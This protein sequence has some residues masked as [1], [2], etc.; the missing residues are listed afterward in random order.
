MDKKVLEM[1]ANK[2]LATFR[3]ISWV[4]NYSKTEIAEKLEIARST[5]YKR[6]ENNSWTV[7]EIELI[8]KYL[9]F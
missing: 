2:K 6:I 1:V 8:N 4:G 9:P 5:L 7:K 3:V